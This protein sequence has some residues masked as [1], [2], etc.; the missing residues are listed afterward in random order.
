MHIKNIK[1][2]NTDNPLLGGLPAVQRWLLLGQA[3]VTGWVLIK[4]IHFFDFVD[5]HYLV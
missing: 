2:V 5:K 4:I 3:G 1:K